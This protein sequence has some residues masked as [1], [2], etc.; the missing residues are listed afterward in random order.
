MSL[1]LYGLVLCVLLFGAA[2]VRAENESVMELR[3]LAE[4]G[5][6]EAVWVPS[7]T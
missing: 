2:T 1:A 5:D 6:A 7:R 3:R 4:Q